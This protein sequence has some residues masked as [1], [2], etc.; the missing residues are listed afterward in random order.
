MQDGLE[1]VGSN[2]KPDDCAGAFSSRVSV[3]LGWKQED[4]FVKAESHHS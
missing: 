3:G 1:G 2:R 4:V